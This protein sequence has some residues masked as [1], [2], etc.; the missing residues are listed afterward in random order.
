[1]QLTNHDDDAYDEN[2]TKHDDDAYDGNGNND[3]VVYDDCDD[4]Q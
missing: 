3:V 1:M 4:K 2:N